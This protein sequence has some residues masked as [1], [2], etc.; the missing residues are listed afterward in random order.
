MKTVSGMGRF[1][2]TIK[3]K[4]EAVQLRCSEFIPA[5]T[6]A[7][8]SIYS[9]YPSETFGNLMISIP[10][11]SETRG[12]GDRYILLVSHGPAWDYILLL[13]GGRL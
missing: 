11:I 3:L 7:A 2:P 12:K 6:S 8:W 13:D 4:D 10:V 9:R 1:P 5:V